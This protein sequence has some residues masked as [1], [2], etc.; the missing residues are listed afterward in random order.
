MGTTQL[1][2]VAQINSNGILTLDTTNNTM[3]LA[4][5]L[6][7]TSD[8]VLNGASFNAVIGKWTSFTV[9]TLAGYTTFGGSDNLPKYYLSPMGIVFLRGGIQ[10]NTGNGASPAFGNIVPSQI[11]GS[12]YNIANGLPAPTNIWIITASGAT[13]GSQTPNVGV[14]VQIFINKT[15]NVCVETTA[16]GNSAA[17]AANLNFITLDGLWYSIY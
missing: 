3:N 1:I 10:S 2:D 16:I 13:S 8:L 17:A 14:M 15:G 9:N 6:N 5:T 4:G 7:V 11:C 12:S